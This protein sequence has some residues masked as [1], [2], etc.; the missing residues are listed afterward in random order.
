MTILAVDAMGGD[1]GP[2]EVCPGVLEG[3]QKYADLEIVFLGD[4]DQV[5]RA[6]EPF[7]GKARYSIV[8]TDQVVTGSEH[9]SSA[10]RSKR[11]SSLRLALEMVR[12]KE[13]SGTV[14]AGNTG[15][16]VAGGVLV[17]GRMKTV[18]RPALGIMVP[19]QSP[20][21]LLDLG[22][23][24]RCKPVNLLQ[25]A[26]L[27]SFYLSQ[28]TGLSHPVVKLLSNGSEDI[29]GDEVIMAA[30]E[31]LKKD[32]KL[33]YQGYIEANEVLLSCANVVVCDGFTGN[34]M[35]KTFEGMTAFGYSL[36]KE[37]LKGRLF[38]KLGLGLCLPM[39]RSIKD[40]VDYQKY[41]G[42]PLLGV[43]GVVVKA[44]GRSKAP[45]LVGAVDVA[46]QSMKQ[47]GL[48]ALEAELNETEK[49]LEVQ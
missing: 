4:Q 46:Y 19:S 33:N 37:E 41:G 35:L 3:A 11:R 42:T 15:A 20:T 47:G 44:H 23:T 36:V 24:V 17:V 16:I 7:E 22:A 5:K 38:A 10:I 26:H 21:F 8:H 25:F 39:I 2:G 18:D 6:C 29:K 9:P 45:A 31:L 32:G 40:K 49:M 1:W 14:S 27:G 34:V 30:R 28:Q 13:A 48:E 43:R 12:S